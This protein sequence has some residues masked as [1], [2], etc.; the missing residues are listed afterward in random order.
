MSEALEG[1]QVATDSGTIGTTDVTPDEGVASPQTSINAPVQQE[2]EHFFD[3]KILDERPELMPAYKQMQAAWTKKMQGIASQSNKIAEYDRFM[4][5][6]HES[7]RQMAQRLG[8]ST[9]QAQEIKQEAQQQEFIPQDWNDVTK[10]IKGQLM[11]D[12]QPII[13]EVHNSKKQSIESKLDTMHPDWRQYE[14]GMTKLVQEHP[15]L[16][17]D[18]SLLYRLAVP[19]SVHQARAAQAAL[20][21]ISAQNDS[22]K[23]GG[24]S[25]TT[26]TPATNTKAKNFQEA[27]ELA[28]KDP[29]V[30]RHKT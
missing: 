10:M 18:P 12:L 14:D 11:Q 1:G 16:A 7:V 15:S 24:G 19:D 8:I 30:L 23:I 26:R 2:E 20:K 13:E 27:Y 17:K 28:L 21:K 9:A 3:P 6:P 4:A 25:T 22:S 29:N 5:N